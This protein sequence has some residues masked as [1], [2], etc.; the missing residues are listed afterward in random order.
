LDVVYIIIYVKQVGKHQIDKCCCEDRIFTNQKGS[1]YNWFCEIPTLAWY[2]GDSGKQ[3]R[4]SHTRLCDQSQFIQ[5]VF[6][7]QVSLAHLFSEC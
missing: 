2:E 7:L 6:T 3:N 1:K 5:V 4:K